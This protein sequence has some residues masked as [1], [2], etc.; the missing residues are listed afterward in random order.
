LTR[1]IIVIE[2]TDARKVVLS[3]GGG[4]QSTAIACLIVTGKLPR[5]DYIVIA[6]TGREAETTWDYLDKH[7]AP[8]LAAV[9]LTVELAGHDLAT[10]DLYS[11]GGSI[12]IPAYTKHSD[13]KI[14]RLPTY[15][16]VEWKRRVMHRW[17]RQ[18]GIKQAEVWLGISV[19]EA[20]RM[21]DSPV[22]W[23]THRYPLI[24]AWMKRADCLA[25]LEANGWPPPP[26]SSCWMCP[27]RTTADWRA[28]TRNDLRRAVEFE[29][30]MREHDPSL[31]LRGSGE[32]L[33][34]GTGGPDTPVDGCEGGWCWS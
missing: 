15:C 2:P 16:S 27:H 33:T 19:D 28:L 11:S 25:L 32:P 31:T 5:P 17:M 3:Y 34:M 23:V 7:A 6:D 13:G 9:G 18:A 21:K 22:K 1:R 14:G 8:R 12:L 20:H 24:D 26:R 10:V 30:D 4:V 29:V